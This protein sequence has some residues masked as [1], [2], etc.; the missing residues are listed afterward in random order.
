MTLTLK[1][2]EILWEPSDEVKQQAN[3]THYLHFLA[4]HKHRYFSNPAALW[5]WSV[6]DLEAFW[7]SLWEYFEIKASRPYTRV[8]DQRKMPGAK[9]FSGAELN[10]AEH[11]FR[12]A[13]RS[14]PAL[15]YQSENQPLGALSW[16]TLT[17]QVASVSAWLR[18]NGVARGDRVAAY[19]PNIPETVVAFLSCASLGAIWSSCSPDFGTG[20][21]VDRFKQ[22]EPKILF[23]VDGYRYNAKA[24]PRRQMLEE[25]QQ[26]L[27]GLK[28]IVL[29]SQ[30]EP[31]GEAPKL[32]HSVSWEEVLQEPGQLR[33]EQV[34]FDH[35]LWILYSS[36]TTGLPKPIVQ[37]HGGIVLEHLK[38]LGLGL[39]LKPNDIFFWYTT[40][41]WMMWNFLVSGLLLGCPVLLYNGSPTYPDSQVLWRCAEEAGVTY[42]GTSAAYIAS[43]MKAGL[44]PARTYDLSKIRAVGTTG[45]PLPPEG[46]DWIYEHLNHHLWLNSISGGTDVCSAFVGGNILLPV[47]PGEIQGRA[48]GAKVEA[49]DA[50]GHSLVDEI[51]ELVVTAPLP[52]MPL[53]FWNDPDNRHYLK[54]YFE[55]YPGVWRHGDWIKITPQGSVVIYGR[56]DATINRH[57][58]RMGSSEI[59]RVVEAFEEIVD[60]LVVGV[61]QPGGKYYMPL[62]VVLREGAALDEALQTKIRQTIRHDVSPHYV[63]DE[64]IA[65]KEL[66]RTLNNKKVEVPVK[67]LLSGLPVEQA[68]SRDALSNPEALDFF[69]KFAAS[70]EQKF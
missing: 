31:G 63:P 34:P 18:A 43:C 52:S 59:Y 4:K 60:S 44:E 16:Q 47:K 28:K 33:F 58:I 26:S 22:I 65:V 36:G 12:N 62:F 41:S 30:F 37:G 29:I 5:E 48:L 38:S 56:S 25:L 53:F 11:I 1:K 35:P 17:R 66:P 23:A 6:N 45:S 24:Y 70:F 39:D 32:P 19:L 68:A 46:F 21:V 55:M 20:S 54:S 51:G 57:G 10:Y 14:R 27:P 49:Y 67:K 64:I 9:W 15:L 42:F 7:A 13:T 40:T 8:L 3:L 2:S 50:A 61:E 69:V